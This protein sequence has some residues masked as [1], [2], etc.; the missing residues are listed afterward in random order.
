MTIT[1]GRGQIAVMRATLIA[2]RAELRSRAGSVVLLA[3]AIAIGLGAGLGALIA[4]DRTDR[5]YAEY[6]AR[7]QVT[8]LVVNPS[9]DSTEFAEALARVPHLRGVWTDLLIRAGVDDGREHTV[10]GLLSD[11]RAGEVRGSPDGRFVA[12]DRPVVDEGRA[13]TGR[14]EVFV[15]AD[16]RAELERRLGR[17]IRTGSRVPIAFYWSG[18]DPEVLGPDVL[19]RPAREFRIGI[20]R[21]RVSGIGRLPDEVL[22]DEVFPRQRLVVSADVARRYECQASVP[23]GGDID[24]ITDALFPRDCARSYRYYALDL[25]DPRRVP[26]TVDRVQAIVQRLNR[27][28]GFADDQG[29]AYYP[30]TT[31]RGETD[32]QVQRA[33]RPLVV[34]LRVF[35]A[36]ALMA[37]MALAA[38]ASGR[39]QRRASAADHIRRALG[40]RVWE[41]VLCIAA[42]SLTGVVIGG[43][44][45]LVV[46]YGLSSIGPIGEVARMDPGGGP[47]APARVVGV[48]T[49][50]VV[51]AL[52]VVVLGLAYATAHRD[53]SGSNPPVPARLGRLRSMLSPPV[54]DGVGL[55]V[56]PRRLALPAAAVIAVGAL[57]AAGTFGTNLGTLVDRSSAYG[58]P[59]QFGALAGGGYGGMAVDAVR[60]D[61]RARPDVADW[62]ELGLAGATLDG[63]AVSLLYGAK[64]LDLPVVDGRS[65]RRAGEAALGVETARRLRVRL[66]QRVRL[67]IQGDPVDARVVGQVVLPTVG[68]VLS[69]RTGLGIGAFLVV[70]DDVMSPE[71]TT[72]VGVRLRAG[73]APSTT[74]TA[75]RKRLGAWD[76]TGSPAQEYPTP[77]RPPEIVNVDSMRRGPLVLAG[78]LAAALLAALVLSI[79]ATVA[80][81]RRDYAIQRSL[82]YTSRQVARSVRWHALTVVTIGVALGIPLGIA[83]GRF[84]WNRFADELGIAPGVTI[85]MTLVVSIVVAAGFGALIA[86]ALPARSA[87]RGNPAEVLRAT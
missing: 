62:D 71:T 73:A 20:E 57:V 2:V 1:G 49:P 21:L 22:A 84:A 19:D 43:L 64:P 67:D 26:A 58:W 65:P 76:V 39:V 4:A 53:A 31:T 72:F 81:R 18:M 41:R 66:G 13:P 8:D 14:G 46:A 74:V 7:A 45:S 70:P 36:V 11:T 9:L 6:E 37:T 38:I 86:S 79:G 78:V 47:S 50:V 60:A 17:R 32:R 63:R 80:G 77:I 30:V 34:A 28:S 24:E 25:D 55:A 68:Q 44:F 83:A 56:G 87:S 48:V 82:G 12:A 85:P 40:M 15:T 59:W 16:Y 33:V 3:I 61:L 54:A 75:L 51:L 10:G 35:G 29:P 5:V 23:P 52:L 27:Q 69:D 42:P